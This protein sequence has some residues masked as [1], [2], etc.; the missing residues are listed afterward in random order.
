MNV[1]IF[2]NVRENIKRVINKKCGLNLS[3]TRLLLFFD[4]HKNETLTMGELAQALS[5]SLSTLSRQIKQK[6]TAALIT[7]ERSKKDSSKSL[8][9]NNDGLAKAQ[10]LKKVLKQI[11]EQIFS[12]WSDEDIQDF[13]NKLQVIVN[14]LSAEEV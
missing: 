7:V 9:L 11:E 5:I 14:N 13:D 6:K 12:T 1:L 3:Q 8:N 4:R 2:N 10:E